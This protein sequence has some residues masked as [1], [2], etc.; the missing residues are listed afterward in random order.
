MTLKDAYCRIEEGQIYLFNMH[1]KP[2]EHGN[3]FNRDPLRKRKLLLHKKE[4]L[5]L[6][7]DVKRQGYSIIPLSAYFIK[8]KDKIEIV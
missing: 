3:M 7:S 2:Y 8:Y 6:Y 5:N 1:I 4:I